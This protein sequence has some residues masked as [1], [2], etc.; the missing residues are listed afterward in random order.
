MKSSASDQ[1]FMLRENPTKK[2]RSCIE[3]SNDLISDIEKLF[4]NTETRAF[5]PY[6]PIEKE[7]LQKEREHQIKI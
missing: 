4:A 3:T 7:N 1:A 5:T 2:R 6:V